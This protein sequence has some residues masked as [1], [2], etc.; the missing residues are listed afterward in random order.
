MCTIWALALK[1][2]KIFFNRKAITET[3]TNISTIY[4]ERKYNTENGNNYHLFLCLTV[5]ADCHID[6]NGLVVS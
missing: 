5:G 2:S 3:S 6:V 4:M 1:A